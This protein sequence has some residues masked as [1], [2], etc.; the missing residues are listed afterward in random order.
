MRCINF[1][2]EFISP[3]SYEIYSGNINGDSLID[4]LDILMLVNLAM[5]N[6]E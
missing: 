3:N 4:I 6:N 2:L 5:D 1:V